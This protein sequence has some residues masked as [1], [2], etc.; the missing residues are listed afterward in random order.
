MILFTNLFLFSVLTPQSVSSLKQEELVLK[1]FLFLPVINKTNSPWQLQADV[2]NHWYS[3]R[4]ISNK[5]IKSVHGNI[6]KPKGIKMCTWN[7][8][9]SLLL[10]K[11]LE[12]R[13]IV[14]QHK[15]LVFGVSEARLREKDELISVEVPDYVM[16]P[17][18]TRNQYDKRAIIYTHRDLLVK[19]G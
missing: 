14:Y 3:F 12:V 5:E 11:M 8:G 1:C 2:F 6:L 17:C 15:P 7:T 4:S 9:N 19:N 10:N 16:H 13:N 18:L